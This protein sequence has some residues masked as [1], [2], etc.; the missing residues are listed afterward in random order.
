MPTVDI[1]KHIDQKGRSEGAGNG[2]PMGMKNKFNKK[3]P[4]LQFSCMVRS[5]M[6]PETNTPTNA[7]HYFS[8]RCISSFTHICFFLQ[9]P[10]SFVRETWAVRLAAWRWHQGI[11]TW[12]TRISN[13]ESRSRK[14]SAFAWHGRASNSRSMTQL[15]WPIPARAFLTLGK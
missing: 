6:E 3:P 8:V 14:A 4:C 1:S 5:C 7:C 2:Y 11:T 9:L 15:K 12:A 13:G 10:F